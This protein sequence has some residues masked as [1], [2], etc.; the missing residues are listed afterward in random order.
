MLALIQNP[1]KESYSIIPCYVS[2]A[3]VGGCTVIVIGGLKSMGLAKP[4]IIIL[5]A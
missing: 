2:I 1:S 3:R 4:T 5:C